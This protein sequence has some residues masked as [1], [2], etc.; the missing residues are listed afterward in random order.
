MTSRKELSSLWKEPGVSYYVAVCLIA[1][2]AIMLVMLQRIYWALSLLPILA[3]VG[4]GFTSFGPFLLVIVIVVCLERM[5][6]AEGSL[7]GQT[8][9]DFILCAAVL[10]YVAAHYRLQSLFVQIVPSDP[11]RRKEVPPGGGWRAVFRRKS[12]VVR[13]R[14]SA[15]GV[16][17]PEIQRLLWTL[18]LGALAAQLLW[19]MVQLLGRAVRA[20]PYEPDLPSS[21]WRAILLAWLMGL[22]G[23]VVAG[24]IGYW[25]H[26]RLSVE[27]AT[28][29]L[30]DQLWA[31]TRREQRRLN[32]WLAWARRR[33]PRREKYS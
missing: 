17:V 6:Y 12:R 1:L 2:G 11:R 27:Q 14:R 30:Q 15:Q 9:L 33:P 22:T 10:A 21:V 32:R 13:Q 23:Y 3:G 24:V 29:Y 25:R 28:L 18:P 5:P 20:E 26:R 31:E 16:A 19:G 7:V 4:A 8:V